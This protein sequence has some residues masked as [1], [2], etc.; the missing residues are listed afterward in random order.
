MI[1]LGFFLFTFF[2]S[3][4]NFQGDLLAFFL[5]FSYAQTFPGHVIMGQGYIILVETESN[6]F[7]EENLGK[8]NICFMVSILLND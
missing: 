6:E 8:M 7:R 2:F 1:T 5:F 4:S 3:S